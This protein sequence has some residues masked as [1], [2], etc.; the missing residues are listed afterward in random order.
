VP[1]GWS[2]SGRQG[3]GTSKQGSGDREANQIKE[4]LQ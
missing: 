3:T 4:Q 1:T 2:K